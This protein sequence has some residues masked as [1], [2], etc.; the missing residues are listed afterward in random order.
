MT[1]TKDATPGIV[2]NCGIPSVRKRLSHLGHCGSN[3]ET[4]PHHEQLKAWEIGMAWWL[5]GLMAW[6]KSVQEIS[7]TYTVLTHFSILEDCE[8]K[9]QPKEWNSTAP[10]MRNWRCQDM[11]SIKR[12]SKLP[13]ICK[14]KHVLSVSAKLPKPANCLPWLHCNCQKKVGIWPGNWPHHWRTPCTSKLCIWLYM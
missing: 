13:T 8:N 14:T 7:P 4:C 9:L 6:W 5:D 3:G 11:P 10:A 1:S 12:K 2:W